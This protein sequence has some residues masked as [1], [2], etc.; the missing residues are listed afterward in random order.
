MLIGPG[1]SRLVE[2][3][4]S[5]KRRF[6]VELKEGLHNDHLAVL[7]EGTVAK[8]APEGP[9]EE[10]AEVELKLVEVG[11]HDATAGVA[12]LDGVAVIVANSS[13]LVGKKVKARVNRVLD[14]TA[15]AT[16]VRPAPPA[17]ADAPIT[18]EAEAEK[19]TRAPRRKKAAAPEAPPKD[20]PAADEAEAVSEEPEPEPAQDAEEAPKPKKKTRRG[21]RGGRG[22]KKKTAAANGDTPAGEQQPEPAEEEAAAAVATIH[23]PEPDLGQSEDAVAE[24]GASP[25]EQPKARKKTRRGSRGG[26]NRRRKPAST[27]TSSES[28]PEAQAE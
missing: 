2:I 11:L 13:K 26:R 7:D 17:A 8:L 20:E 21:S 18:A 1:A 4:E 16:L 23:V 5:T 19:P 10:G 24:D 28:P 25:D 14:G 22:R 9:V 3:E 15:Y 27:A 6:F 12:K